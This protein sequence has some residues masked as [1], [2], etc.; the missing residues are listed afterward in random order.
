MSQ[1]GSIS[2]A[3]P[4]TTNITNDNK[5]KNND[6]SFES[7]IDAGLKKDIENATSMEKMEKLG[8]PKPPKPE[9]TMHK[10]G[11]FLT[12]ILGGLLL[13]AGVAAAV[14]ATVAS[15]G[16]AAG[17]VAG[18]A[19]TV[20]G[21]VGVTGA[22]VIAGAAGAA[23]IGLIAGSHAM[24]PKNPEALLQTQQPAEKSVPLAGS[25]TAVPPSPL[26]IAASGLAPVWVSTRQVPS[27]CLVASIWPCGIRSR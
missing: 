7:I 10:V 25:T 15:C 26:A 21:A 18:V 12:G 17:V 2:N 8:G 20:V 23:G 4:N 22:S 9:S 13:A 27:S 16:L 6:D 11:R 14:A 5:I 1:V 19:A 3:N 24:K